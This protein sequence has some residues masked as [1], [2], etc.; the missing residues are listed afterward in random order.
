MLNSLS[1]YWMVLKAKLGG[2]RGQDLLEYA[3]IGGVVAVA[4]IAVGAALS[5]YVGT[6]FD[7][8]GSCITWQDDCDISLPL[9]GG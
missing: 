1:V 2:E 9:G 3:L 5:G 4:I 7:K 8:I 6:M